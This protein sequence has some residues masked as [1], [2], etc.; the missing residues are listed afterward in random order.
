MENMD[1]GFTVPKM[2][3]DKSAKNTPNA[4]NFI[5][6]NCLPKPKSLEFRRKKAALGDRSPLSLLRTVAK[7][8]IQEIINKIIFTKKL[9]ISGFCFLELVNTYYFT[10]KRMP[11]AKFSR[12][13]N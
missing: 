5:C 9:F 4:T 6:T 11:N 8:K 12:D 10:K 1:K 3:A 13:F 7:K 2:G